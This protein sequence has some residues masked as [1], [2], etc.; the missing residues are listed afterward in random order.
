MNFLHLID[1]NMVREFVNS[2]RIYKIK[3]SVNDDCPFPNIH[4]QLVFRN[5]C[6]KH[7]G[8]IASNKPFLS[9]NEWIFELWLSNKRIDRFMD[10]FSS[11]VKIL[12]EKKLKV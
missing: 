6:R 3:Y 8:F 11:G 7:G 10:E 5:V 9:T 1:K 12:S 4:P 2:I